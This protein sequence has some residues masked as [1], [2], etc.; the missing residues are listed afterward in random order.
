MEQGISRSRTSPTTT[1]TAP[2]A[3]RASCAAR[4]HCSP[5]TSTASARARWTWSRRC[6]PSPSTPGSNSRAGRAGIEPTDGR[7]HEPVWNGTRSPGAGCPT[8]PR[9]STCPWAAR[10]S[11]SSTARRPS[12]APR[13]RARWPSFCRPPAW[14]SA[15]C[16]E[17]WCCGGPAAEMGY[18]E[19]A[20]RFAEHN[21]ADWRAVGAKRVIAIDP[22]DYI[23][24]T[25]DYPDYFG[26]EFDIEIVLAVELVAELVRE[27]RLA[28]TRADRPSRHVPRRLPAQQAKGHPRGAARD[29][30]RDPGSDLQGR[31]PRH[32]VVLLLGSGRRPARSNAPRSTA[33]IAAGE[34]RRPPISRST[35]WSAPASGPSAHSTE[36]G[37]P[38]RSRSRSMD[39]MELVAE[40]AGLD[41]GG[42]RR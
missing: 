22:H 38:A 34:W 28:L 23:S 35:R 20:R 39:L 17:Q 7:R 10:R 36:A 32:A 29:P 12:T 18:V 8:G 19:Q 42:A 26:D 24:F 40:S 31:R 14:S 16:R 11:C 37:A 5:G 33:E 3:G 2:S 6:G 41:D 15:S 9:A 1:S 30:A 13:C 27:G 4:T 25:E 21:L